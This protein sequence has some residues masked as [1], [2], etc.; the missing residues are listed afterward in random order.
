VGKHASTPIQLPPN[1]RR[2]PR[3]IQRPVPPDRIIHEAP[4]VPVNS[5][6]SMVLQLGQAAAT[7]PQCAFDTVPKAET[8]PAEIGS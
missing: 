7:Q 6:Q 3:I 2:H 4:Q 5:L 8:Y 1:K